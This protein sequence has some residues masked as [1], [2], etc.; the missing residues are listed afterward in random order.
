LGRFAW[1]PGFDA[2]GDYG[3][4]FVGTTPAGVQSRR[5]ARIR[6][7]DVNRPPIA[8]T[9]SIVLAYVGASRLITAC[10][11]SDPDGD[12]LTFRWLDREG[13]QVG[14]RCW[15]IRSFGGATSEVFDVEVSDGS[16]TSTA[17]VRVEWNAG[18]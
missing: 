10:G 16:A 6:V 11:S 2:A 1:T 3:V 17:S 5:T 8:R 9:R 12:P 18:D 13:S 4:T 14:D 15:L 7:L